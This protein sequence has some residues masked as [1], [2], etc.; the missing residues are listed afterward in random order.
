[1]KLKAVAKK[2]SSIDRKIVA[3]GGG[4]LRIGETLPI[5]R[6]I[7]AWSGKER[8][9]ILFIPTA[10]DDLPAY[11]STFKHIYEN[12]GC[13]VHVLRLL[14]HGRKDNMR[15]TKK[16]ILTADIIYIG[17]GD[18]DLLTAEWK[19]AR[20]IPLIKSAYKRGALIAGLSAGC[21]ILYEHLVDSDG[22]NRRL[23]RGIGILK[24]VVLPHYDGIAVL[25]QAFLP[26]IQKKNISITAIE[27]NCGALYA[28]EA[29]LGTIVVG[30][31]RAFTINPPYD[32]KRL[33]HPYQKIT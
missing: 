2:S 10:S 24:G 21:A 31:A 23:K 11:I 25:S 13:K 3:I 19:R 29:L 28:N 9:I 17:G 5:D 26:S 8:P 1:M 4:L 33:V 7:V 30:N 6:Y 27:D 15:A 12:L 18:Y 20:I 22:K 32:K 14:R 16:L